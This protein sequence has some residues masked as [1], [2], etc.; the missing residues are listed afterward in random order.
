MWRR[1]DFK[2]G[3]KKNEPN[4]RLYTGSLFPRKGHLCSGFALTKTGSVCDEERCYY[5]I[6]ITLHRNLHKNF[7]GF[8]MD[9]MHF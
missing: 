9:F 6:P 4:R 7:H 5:S 1:C 2:S 8:M 3:V